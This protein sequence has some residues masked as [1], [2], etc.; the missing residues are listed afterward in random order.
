MSL[1]KPKLKEKSHLASPVKSSSYFPPHRVLSHP[2]VHMEMGDEF[3][4]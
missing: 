1:S 2:R 4:S 3:T